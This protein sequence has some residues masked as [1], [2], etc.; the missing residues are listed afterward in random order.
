MG[1]LFH[2]NLYVCSTSHNSK[3]RPRLIQRKA[4][5]CCQKETLSVQEREAEMIRLFWSHLTMRLP[6]EWITFVSHSGPSASPVP[7]RS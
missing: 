7:H 3:E 6:E 4:E 2:Q 1:L 5:A